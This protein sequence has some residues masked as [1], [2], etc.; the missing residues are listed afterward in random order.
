MYILIL[1]GFSALLYP[2]SIAGFFFDDIF[3]SLLSGTTQYGD[4]SLIEF[5]EKQLRQW[6][7]VGRF[8]P[9]SIIVGY[10]IWD[11]CDSLIKYRVIHL[12][13]VA[14]NGVL[15]FLFIRKISGSYRLAGLTILLLPLFFQFNPRW[16]GVTSF[17]PLNQLAFSLVLISWLSLIQYLNTRLKKFLWC[18]LFAEFLALSTYEVAVV[19]LPVQILLIYLY[20]SK[21]HGLRKRAFIG[22]TIVCLV[23][24]AICIY[25]IANRASSYE[26]INSSFTPSPLTFFYQFTS[27]L[28][29]SFIANKILPVNFNLGLFLG[30]SVIYFLITI[31]FWQITSTQG[32]LNTHVHKRHKILL[33]LIAVLLGAIPPALMALSSRY[34]EIVSY[35]DP[36][37]VVYIQYWG[38]ALFFAILFEAL[39]NKTKLIYVIVF[40][41]VSLV[42]ALTISVNASRIKDQNG[43]FLKPRLDMQ[44]AIDSGFMKQLNAGD[45]L[46]VDSSFPWESGDSCAPYF[47]MSLKKRINCISIAE[48]SN[49]DLFKKKVLETK[50]GLNNIYTFSRLQ[51]AGSSNA[52]ILGENS[53]VW[54]FSSDSVDSQKRGN[55]YPGVQGLII[56][57]ILESGF[58]GWEPSGK[59]EWSWS[60]GDSSIIFH[61]LKSSAV[62]MNLS[63]SIQ[64]AIS[65]NFKV[66]LNGKQL[67]SKEVK[68]DLSKELSLMLDLYPGKNTVE[69][70]VDGK[71]VRLSNT[72]ERF[73]SFKIYNIIIN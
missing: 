4:L 14:L 28:P 7:G 73:F 18:S 25:L 59:K 54:V 26:G 41:L 70:R 61:N 47:S 36:Y 24:L 10:S 62:K 16:D 69:L 44:K 52:L 12:S 19:V 53:G 8:F 56:G 1:L 50:A 37:I 65:Q 39:F 40:L 31:K 71:S 60:K 55:F 22:C 72:D 35:G 38:C 48:L 68:P 43:T 67:T 21:Y 6:F 46:V 13:F 45:L 49:A 51:N 17:G 30:L 58:Y 11:F 9:I 15:F 2:Y 57:P 20:I 63:F 3:N 33:I 64:S 34:Q 23:Y 5:I 42:I 29:L 32:E 66:Y 27:A